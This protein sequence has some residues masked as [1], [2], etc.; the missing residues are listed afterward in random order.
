MKY[1]VELFVSATTT[2]AK[3]KCFSDMD[4]FLV[5]VLEEQGLEVNSILSHK[6]LKKDWNKSPH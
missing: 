4:S 2:K 3:N 1:K 5:Q 6:A